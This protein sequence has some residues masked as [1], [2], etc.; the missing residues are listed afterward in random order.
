[1]GLPT[2]A[3]AT[4]F[5]LPSELGVADDPMSVTAPHLAWFYHLVV[6]GGVDNGMLINAGCEVEVRRVLVED[7]GFV[8]M[9]LE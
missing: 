8:V 5:R 7:R 6:A 1:M 3:P 2:A 4:A 9:V